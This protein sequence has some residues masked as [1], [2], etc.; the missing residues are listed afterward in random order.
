MSDDSEF[1]SDEARRG[2]VTRGFDLA[3]WQVAAVDAWQRG[4]G[5]R[6]RGTLEIFTG[7]GKTLIALACAERAA[8]ASGPLRVAV[9]VPTEALARQWVE[10]VAR[11]TN[12]PRVEIGLLGA[13]GHDELRDKTVLVAVLNT[14]AHRLPEMA[15]V[16]GGHLL[17]VVDECHR[18]GAPT[19]AR[20]LCTSADYRLGLSATPDREEVDDDGEPLEYDAQLVG[21]ALGGVVYRF[22][23]RDARTEGWLPEFEVHHHGVELLRAERAEYER[24]S[25]QVDDI[26]DR[27]SDLGVDALRSRALLSRPAPLGPLAS[28]YVAATSK[29]KDL[30]YRA[31]ERARVASLLVERLFNRRP[32]A[33]VL[34]FHERVAEAAWLHELLKDVVPAGLVLEHS[35]L[36]AAQRAA[37]IDAFRSGSAP[38]LVSV[39]S[40][41]EGIDVPSADVGISVASTSSVRQRIQALGRVLRRTFDDSVKRAEMHVL[42]VVDSV[43]EL[44]Y[45]KE[46]WA[47]LTG[48][49]QNRYWRWS[50]ES[51][52]SE[53]QDGPPRTPFPSEEQEWER[54]GGVPAAPV[55]WRGALPA[56]EYSVDTRGTVTTRSG[57]LVANPQS[58]AEMVARVRGRPGGRF[59]V[60]PA[61]DLV[62]VRE[63]GGEGTLWVAGQLEQAFSIRDQET[64]DAEPARVVHLRPGDFYT[65]QTDAFNGEYRVLQKRGG[66]I[67][68]SLGGGVR[69]F[70]L[71]SGGSPDKIENARRVLEAWRQVTTSGLKIAV[72]RAW[73]AWYL[74]AGEPR[75]LASVPDGFAWPTSDA[76]TTP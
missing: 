68:R 73:H 43:D 56:R 36:P 7:G 20:V 29:R 62:I 66:V 6:Y 18:A 39:K 70:A 74:E 15:R 19:F 13:G 57:A 54:L 42:Y 10:S 65:G 63:A 12:V 53:T 37:A 60:T 3:P 14:A 72:N 50:V 48:D 23:L 71:T 24:L 9:V 75:F 51:S 34:L 55:P 33:R 11:Y 67:E 16:A 21:Q 64:G 52:E 1:G 25:R 44:I 41:V 58:V 76:E 17:L 35:R 28:A 5:D 46:D 2:F 59:Y 4:S 32:E 61:H 31:A 40:L 26:A 45:A 27:M 30:L 22:T 49:A 69:E 38:V 47:D 8:A